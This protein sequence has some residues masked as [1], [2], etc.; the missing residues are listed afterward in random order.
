M[1]LLRIAFLLAFLPGALAGQGPGLGPSADVGWSGSLHLGAMR[2]A[3]RTLPMVALAGAFRFSPRFEMGGGGVFSP[4]PVRISPQGSSDRSEL[5][6]GYGGLLLRYGA[7]P[8]GERWGV[9][10]ALLLG[11]GRARVTSPLIDA[12]IASENFLLFEPSVE[13]HLPRAPRLRPVLNLGYRMVLGAEGLP[14]VEASGLRGA[15]LALSFN[16]V[17]NP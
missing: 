3:D 13:L 2:A 14:R 15:T 16:M 12:D 6:L 7:P 11:A 4:T 10:P 9:R 8:T 17:R 1:L 5:S